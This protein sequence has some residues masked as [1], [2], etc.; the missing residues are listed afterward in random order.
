MRIVLDAM[1]SDNRP[2]PDVAGAVLAARTHGDTVILVGDE[3]QIKAELAKHDL[4]GLTLEVVHA[5][6]E[7]FME[8]KPAE[9]ARNKSASSMHV[10]M[11]LVEKGEADG[12]VTVGNTGAALAV[13]TLYNI[14]RIRGV[15]RPA[16]SVVVPFAGN[17]V[18]MVDIGANMD[19]KAE[20]LVQFAV[21]SSIH[22]ERMV[23]IERPKVAL[24]SIGEEPGKGNALIQETDALLKEVDLNYVGNIEPKDMTRG[25]ADVVVADGFVGN[26]VAKS[27][28]TM[29]SSLFNAIRAHARQGWR[30]KIGALLMRPAYRQIYKDHDPFE[31]GGAVLVGLNHVVIIG[32]GRSDAYAIKN[33]IRQA[34]T[35]VEGELVQAIREQLGK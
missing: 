21:M 22:A 29:G 16:L 2:V 4:S 28:E 27:L 6:D 15:H 31:I 30:A 5:P 20:W 7:I 11:E 25:A 9:A 32:H 8:D 3:R 33:A 19:C 13:G 24:L 12:F 17:P 1:G 10:G 35:A 26:M 34:R 18:V 14:R 23:G